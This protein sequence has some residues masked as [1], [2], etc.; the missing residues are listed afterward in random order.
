[1]KVV[2]IF[3]SLTYGGIETM[4]VNI[5]NTQ[6]AMGAEVHVVILNDMYEEKLIR[7]FAPAVSVHLLHRRLKTKG[8]GFVLRLN[9]LL[10]QLQPEAIH[11]HNSHL[12]GMLWRKPLSRV[13]S[14]TLHDLPSGTL[15]RSALSRLC[16]VLDFTNPGNVTFIDRIPKV[17]AISG[18][19]KEML[20]DRYHVD[21]TVV[22]N[23]I[24]TENFLPRP[25]GDAH[26]PMRIVQVS[27][28]EHDKKG[29]DL[30]I[31]AAAQLQGK[32]HVDFIGV[33]SSKEYLMQL[34]RELKA[35]QWVTFL[36]KQTQAYIAGHLKDYDLFVQPSRWEGFGLT[37]AEAMAAGVPVIVSAGQG[38]AEVTC[39][40]TY[41]WTFENGSAN[42]LASVI[43]YIRTHY[44][45]AL[46]KAAD[47]R[48]HVIDNYDIKVTARKYLE[49]YV[50]K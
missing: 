5:A 12:Y 1:M 50:K 35:E 46:I 37:V 34:T 26:T 11:L 30:L 36:G 22:C 31:Q 27:R 3:W 7:S 48:R 19:V 28:L 6:A 14:V 18:A 29:Q 2:H 4:L 41:G 47:A 25:A 13:A 24:M 43:E 44:D 49:L 33:G 15:R 9:R 17:F 38:P 21:S 23:G 32:I 20:W 40:D 10:M 16:P 45:E 42:G 39:N 8:L